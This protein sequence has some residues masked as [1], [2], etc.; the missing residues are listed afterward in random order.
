MDFLPVFS[1]GGEAGGVT[2][3]DILKPLGFALGMC[4]FGI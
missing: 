4:L 3:A 2:G 1:F